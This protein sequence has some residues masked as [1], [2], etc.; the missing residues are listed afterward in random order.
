MQDR[1]H[2]ASNPTLN[3]SG[4][5]IHQTH[6][7]QMPEQTAALVLYGRVGTYTTRTASMKAGDHGDKGLWRECANS[8]RSQVLEP[9]RAAGVRLAVFVQSW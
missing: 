1:H 5:L 3:S 6:A 8:I 9:W 4:G 2:P 7:S